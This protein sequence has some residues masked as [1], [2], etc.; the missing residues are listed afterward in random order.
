MTTSKLKTAV[1]AFKAGDKAKAAALLSQLVRQEPNN[2]T[3]WLWLSVCVTAVDQKRF[4][5]HKVLL[6]NPDNDKA[7]AALVKLDAVAQ[8]DI[9]EITGNYAVAKA[10]T[11]EVEELPLNKAPITSAADATGSDLDSQVVEKE[12][13]SPDPAPVSA[14]K[15]GPQKGRPKLTDRRSTAGPYVQSLLLPN[16]TVLAVA[17]PHWGLFASPGIL[18]AFA[19]ICTFFS[20]LQSAFISTTAN[21]EATAFMTF[22]YFAIC[23]GPWWLLG[24]AR[25]LNA[26]LTYLSTEFALT[27]KRII[28]KTGFIRR[29]SLELVLDKVE[30]I[31]V[32]Q[33][34]TGRLFDFGTLVIGGSGGTDQKFP[35][36]SRPMQLKRQIDKIL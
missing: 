10:S 8:P 31:G 13:I 34:V 22:F 9:D 12:V 1:S 29:Q 20:T 6:L 27:D 7:Q 25:L 30:S 17:R 19:L 3:A 36:I 4:C 28:G 35:N 32:I 15:S 14:G 11:R 21:S 26:T 24:G 16:E 5:L 33:G 18:V 23:A 2:E